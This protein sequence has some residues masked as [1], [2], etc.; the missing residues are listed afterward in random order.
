MCSNNLDKKLAL[1]RFDELITKY[2]VAHAQQE[3]V[4]KLAEPTS[5]SKYRQAK[6]MQI[7]C[8]RR[9]NVRKVGSFS[10]VLTGDESSSPEM[11]LPL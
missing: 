7:K 10:R 4:Q 6:E 11:N 5:S 2:S 8:R 9:T 1:N 3:R